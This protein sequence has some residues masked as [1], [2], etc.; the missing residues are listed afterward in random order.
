MMN[1]HILDELFETLKARKGSDSAESYVASLYDKGTAHIC[2][3][4]REEA[5]EAIVEALAGDREKLAAE[6]A[7]LLF[8]LMT[9]WADQ[10]IEPSDIFE[11]LEKRLGISGHDEKASRAK[12]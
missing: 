1:K 11:I 6:S 10:G 12:P 9:L 3:K 2:D 8:H 4:V 5:E 7:D